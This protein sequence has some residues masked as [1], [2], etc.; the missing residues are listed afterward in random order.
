M[1]RVGPVLVEVELKMSRRR[2][3]RVVLP[4]EEGPEMPIRSV[5]G[6]GALDRAAEVGFGGVEGDGA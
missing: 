5:R 4:L 3:A 1:L 2:R 6:W